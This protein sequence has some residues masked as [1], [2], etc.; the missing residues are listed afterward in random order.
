LGVLESEV[1]LPLGLFL[2]YRKDA[3]ANVKAI[4][5]AAKSV[6]N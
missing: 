6:G 3:D 1:Q 2:A 4:V 5:E